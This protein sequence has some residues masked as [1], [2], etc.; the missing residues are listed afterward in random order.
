[1]AATTTEKVGGAGQ[2]INVG[3][4]RSTITTNE[5]NQLK[6]GPGKVGHVTIWDVG[7]TATL[8]IYDHASTTNNQVFKWLS[9]DGK[10]TFAIQCPMDNGIRVVTGGTFGGANIVWV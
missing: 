1:M 2:I 4:R 6:T 3:A 10:G 7:T 5:T 8:D 9:A